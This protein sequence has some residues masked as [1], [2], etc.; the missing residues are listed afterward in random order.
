MTADKRGLLLIHFS[1]SH[2]SILLLLWKFVFKTNCCRLYNVTT[3]L[4]LQQRWNFMKNLT[5]C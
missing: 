1:S 4:W 3:T 2:V 5:F